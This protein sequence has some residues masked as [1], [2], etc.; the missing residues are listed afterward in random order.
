MNYGISEITMALG[1]NKPGKISDY[2]IT[3]LLTD[4]RKLSDPT[5]TLFFALSTKTND[6]HKY[7]N[8]L[9]IEGVRNF[10]VSS[11]HSSWS[12]LSDANFLVVKDPLM[13]LQKIA[14][15][16]RRKFDIPVIGITGSNGKTIVKEWLYQLLHKDYNITRS[17]RSYNS[18]TGVP[19]SVWQLDDLTTLGIFEAGISMTDEMEHLESIIHPT[20]GIFTKLGEAHQENFASLQQKC[21]EKLELF[22]NSEVIIYNEDNPILTQCI[23]N[24]AMSHKT[25]TWSFKNRENPLFIKSIKS[26]HDKSIIH[27]SFLGFD[28]SFE[29]PFVDGA[30]IENAITCLATMLY[31][32]ILPED[33]KERMLLLEPVAMRLDVREGKNNCILINDTYNSDF[34]SI[35]I[36]LE[37]QSQRRIDKPLKKT[38]ILSDIFQSGLLPKTL[39]KKVSEIIE[40]NQVDK[41]IGIG[42][43][44]SQFKDFFSMEK[45]FFT[46]TDEFIDSQV[47]K[48]FRNELILV[49][50][51][52]RFHFERIVTLLEK[53]IHETV[54]EVNLD[55]LVHNFNF[56]KSKISPNVKLISMVKANGYGA[57]AT[58][59][60]KTLQYHRCGYLAVAIA[61]EGVAL[62]EDGITMPIIVLNSEIN[63]F[64]ELYSSNLEPEVYN[65]RILKAFIKEAERSGVTDYPIH[66]KLDTGM[67]RLGFVSDEIP[68]MIEILQNQKSLRVVSTFSH[69][70]AS[71]SWIFD[72]F[73]AKQMETFEELSLQ[74]ESKLNY[75]INRHILNSAGIERFPNQQ[76]DMVRL[77]IGLYGISASGIKGLQNVCTLKTTIL[78][79]KT[80]NS[81][82]SV[83]YGRK[84]VLEHQARIA[85]IRI[86]YAD[87]LSRQFGNRKGKVFINGAYAPIIGNVCMDLCMIDVTDIK[88]EEGDSVI[89]FGED[90]PVI[91]L[92]NSINTIPY[93][94]LTA[95][96]PRVKR[97]YIKE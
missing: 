34:N 22:I 90:L 11:K 43:D 9:Y 69:L 93:E 44:I 91:D 78:Q 68:E 18:Q 47:W 6:G 84:E 86:G 16:H 30:S 25:F 14:A 29:I 32:R 17:P 67:H 20:I 3:T 58:E 83:G 59:I 49:K 36:A 50:G 65:F 48:D 72:D 4:S 21:N 73:T 8:D 95:V 23:E 74:I 28:T 77:G 92:A 13:A 40:Q 60:A 37:F 80:L 35:K 24:M 39:Y 1:I 7:V 79:I 85:T 55:A 10:V 76:F 96:S 61:S 88:A 26:T 2:T 66:I 82:E 81:S 53:R 54:L 64:E 75:N 12:K 38:L 71:E 62:R 57:G 89:I 97:I 51:S 70:A 94:I 19:L 52:R 33:L 56:Y 31:L 87:G 15:F 5:G 41:I 63:G 46:T 42:R 27:Y 45:N